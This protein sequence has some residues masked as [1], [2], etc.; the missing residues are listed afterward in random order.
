MKKCCRCKQDK[1]A[2]CFGR[3]AARYDG[4]NTVC[5]PCRLIVWRTPENYARAEQ[6][7]KKRKQDCLRAY[8]GT[9]TCCGEKNLAFLVMDHINGGGT[10]HR[11]DLRLGGYRGGDALY[12]WLRR[13]NYPDGFQVL[14]A[15]CN[16]AKERKE[17]CPHNPRFSNDQLHT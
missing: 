2:A 7:R 9:C 14:C 3:N 13:M 8:G 15:N 4:L 5:K 12:R 6:N 10:A 11:R 16:M 17:G 1:E